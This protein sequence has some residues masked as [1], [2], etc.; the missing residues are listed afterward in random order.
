MMK[1]VCTC[2]VVHD[3]GK[4]ILV[5]DKLNLEVKERV[6]ELQT[7]RGWKLMYVF[8]FAIIL[9]KCPAFLILPSFRY[10]SIPFDYYETRH[11]PQLEITRQQ[12][13]FLE[14]WPRLIE[15]VS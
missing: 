5:A 7:Y 3:N 14:N 4:I 6:L 2:F 13:Y 11:R 15:A 12:N 10:T 9:R 1:N 8:S